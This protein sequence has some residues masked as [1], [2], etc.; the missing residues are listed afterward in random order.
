MKTRKYYTFIVCN[1]TPF[2]AGG[3]E[4]PIKFSKKGGG[5]LDRGER[6]QLLEGGDFLQGGCNFHIKNK[7]KSE[8]VN[9]KKVYNQKYLSLP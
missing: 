4:L 8:I 5:E 3:V 6:S 2:S 7:V 9:D 1:L